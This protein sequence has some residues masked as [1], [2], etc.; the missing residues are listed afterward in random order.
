MMRGLI[1]CTA[2][3][4]LVGCKHPVLIAEDHGSAGWLQIDRPG[5]SRPSNYDDR[6][7][8]VPLA[9]EKVDCQSLGVPATGLLVVMVHGLQGDGTEFEEV[10]PIIAAANPVGMY[11]YRWVPFDRLEP[12]SDIFA[13]GLSR[14]VAC[15]PE[16]ETLVVA[17]SA[18]GV[19]VS[20]SA[21]KLFLPEAMK[22]G[23]L[24]LMTV[25]S[26]LAG[27]M[28]RVRHPDGKTESRFMLD[29]GTRFTAYNKPPAGVQAVHLRTSYPADKVMQPQGDFIPNDPKVGIPGAAQ[30]DL[31]R[32]LGH[33]EAL[34]WVAKKIADGSWRA[35]FPSQVATP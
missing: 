34:T 27:T 30:I 7:T 11:M 31:P 2:A 20:Y 35:W 4:A 18:G 29:L 16:G 22:P 21:S 3:L 9:G 8:K 12:L 10:V 1:V 23:A 25:S 33:V 14:L 24:K 28:N 32:E 26:P 17:H 13:L 19:V 5:W 15:R 6:F